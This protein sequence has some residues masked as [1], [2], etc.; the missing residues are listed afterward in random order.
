MTTTATFSLPIVGGHTIEFSLAPPAYSHGPQRIQYRATE[1][2]I[3]H[4]LD[5]LLRAMPTVRGL[6][7]E[8]PDVEMRRIVR[9]SCAGY[10][11]EADDAARREQMERLGS[12]DVGDDPLCEARH[13]GWED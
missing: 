10:S 7:G 1:G 6:S 2:Y 12:R 4:H 8:A 13:T 9:A 11:V 5:G 3:V